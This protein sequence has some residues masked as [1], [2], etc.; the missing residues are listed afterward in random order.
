MP[1]SAPHAKADPSHHVLA[2]IEDPARSEERTSP[3]HGVLCRFEL[4]DH[5]HRGTAHGV[6]RDRWRRG[7]LDRRPAF[8]RLAG[9]RPRAE[10]AARV[11]RLAL[12]DVGGEDGRGV[13]EPFRVAGDGRL[14]PVPVSDLELGEQGRAPSVDLAGLLEAEPAA[15]PAVAEQRADRIL[16]LA[17]KLGDVV[18]LVADASAVVGP[19]GRELLIADPAAVDP[20]LVEAQ[21][22]HVEARPRDRAGD[23][24]GAPQRGDRRRAHRRT[25]ERRCDPPRRPV[26]GLEKADLEAG[27]VTPAGWLS[28]GVEALHLPQGA[29]ARAEGGALVDD[30]RALVRNDLAA[31]PEV[32]LIPRQ[33]L[34]VGGDQQAVGALARLRAIVVQ[35]PEETG[36]VHSQPDGVDLILTAER[37]GSAGGHANPPSR[38]FRAS[39][40]PRMARDSPSTRRWCTWKQ[41]AWLRDQ[42]FG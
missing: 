25:P 30:V 11:Q 17:E 27:R 12:H 31:V 24:E 33:P 8:T 39:D 36:L 13:P 10:V 19:A 35:L 41:K 38:G 28:R 32:A 6:E 9:I 34:R 14:A 5:P 1:S 16:A 3:A 2:E 40:D 18:D 23:L 7:E 15:V 4:A 26:G 37:T 22:G 29:L 20:A 42:A 21:R